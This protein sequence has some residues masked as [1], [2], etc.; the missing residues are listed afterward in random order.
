MKNKRSLQLLVTLVFLI[1]LLA[2]AAMNWY[3]TKFSK[4]PVFG[5]VSNQGTILKGH[6]IR[7]FNLTNEDGQTVST[8]DWKD[9]IVIVDFF[10]SHCPSICPA[11]TNNLKKV[12]VTFKNDHDVLINSFTVDPS[13]DSAAQL[14]SFSNRMNIDRSNWHLITGDKKEIYRLAR[15]G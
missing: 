10:F 5:P 12:A 3:N 9:K 7:D 2:F 14:K 4:L 13:R 6:T 1:P 8:R 11:M 15:N